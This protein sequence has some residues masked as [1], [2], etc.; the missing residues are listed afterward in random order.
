MRCKYAANGSPTAA[1]FGSDIVALLTGETDKN[2]LIAA[3][4]GATEIFSVYPAGWEMFDSDTGTA[5]EWVLRSACDGDPAQFKYLRLRF[6]IGASTIMRIDS[7]V[8]EDWNPTTNTA[9]NETTTDEISTFRM[10]IS[11]WGDG[12]Q[13]FDIFA[14]NRY[15]TW[16]NTG[17]TGIA[18]SMGLA[19][20]EITRTHPCLA[21]GSGYVPVITTIDSWYTGTSFT[22]QFNA[23]IPRILDDIGTTD[24]INK[25]LRIGNTSSRGEHV[26]NEYDNLS[27]AI[28]YDNA[29]NPFYALNL[30]HVEKYE[31]VGAPI[32]SSALGP[33]YSMEAG[34]V[35]GFESDTLHTL[36]T[37]NDLRLIW[38][39]WNISTS[40][41]QPKFLFR[42]EG[43]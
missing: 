38:P 11:S 35:A 6:F 7:S 33:I 24:L 37:P 1:N 2:N 22:S 30:I 42:N 31:D 12:V 29:G 15:V 27:T 16:R 14:T 26:T 21:V 32:G 13:I 43:T 23:R 34:I 4:P 9:T 8:M 10:P 40:K 28:V 18:P 36:D 3:L 19:A 17:Y 41:G 25:A 20:L 39:E 5:D